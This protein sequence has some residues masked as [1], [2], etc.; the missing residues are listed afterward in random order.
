MHLVSVPGGRGENRFWCTPAVPAPS[1]RS[2]HGCKATSEGLSVLEGSREVQ[3]QQGLLIASSGNV[4]W[5]NHPGSS[6]SMSLGSCWAVGSLKSSLGIVFSGTVK[7][8]PPSSHDVQGSALP[9]HFQLFLYLWVGLDLNGKEQKKSGWGWAKRA[10]V[11]ERYK[12]SIMR[13]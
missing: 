3:S 11:V 1:V 12:L 7:N 8:L 2:A 6:A 9:K 5:S 4:F 10:K 13:Q